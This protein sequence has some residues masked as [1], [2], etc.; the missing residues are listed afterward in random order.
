M[1]N[2]KKLWTLLLLAA[3]VLASCGGTETVGK[4]T[5]NPADTAQTVAETAPETEYLDTLPDTDLGGYDFRIVAQSTSE[6]QNFYQEE[7]DG[8]PINDA[9]FNRDLQT[10]ERLNISITTTALADRSEAA[11]AVIKTVTAGD[12]AY[13]MVITAMSQGINTM[14]SGGVLVDLQMLP[15]LTLTSE[16]WAKSIHDNMLLGGKQYFTTGVLSPQYCQSPM[17]CAFNVQI[18]EDYGVGDIYQTVLDGKWTLDFVN[19]ANKIVSHD[20]NGDGEMTVDDFYGLAID[21]VFG[22]IMYAAGRYN[23]I[24][25][26]NSVFSVDLASER[27]MQIID[28]CAAILGNTDLVYHNLKSDGSSLLVFK[29]GRSLVV[30]ADMLDMLKFRE[31]EADFGIIPTP[32]L[33]ESQEGYVTLCQ[34]WLP[35]GIAVPLNCAD[36]EKTG[37]VMETMAA[38]SQKTILPAAYETTLQGKLSRDEVSVQMLDL[39]FENPQFDFITAFDFGGSGSALRE[40]VIG[41]KENFVSTYASM[42]NK[43]EDAINSVVA[44]GQ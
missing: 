17:S 44:D 23:P 24:S 30:N 33:D 43:V 35:T 36:L 31:M 34:T 7:K 1:K 42:R 19:E 3:L 18:A 29:E 16:L 6:R 4:D 21:R 40:A 20:L 11:S 13:E 2:T 37:L 28:Q 14:V 9:I 26:T 22:N 32:K 5:A 15:H 10:S 41:V 12:P 27:S 39:I 25:E 38:I 8:E